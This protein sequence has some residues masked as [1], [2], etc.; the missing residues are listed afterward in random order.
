MTTPQLHSLTPLSPA[1][2]DVDA[3][4]RFYE[5]ALGFTTLFK[6]GQ[7]TQIAMI[8][9]GDISIM[10]C[11]NADKNL[12]D[13]TAFRI[14]TS[15]IESLYQE[16]VGKTPCPIHPNGKLEKKPWGSTEFAVLDPAGVC[17]TFYEFSAG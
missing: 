9:R 15:N 17:I 4:V 6:D 14:R 2:A 12:A 3:T 8:K 5:E 11:L 10:L 13:N 7:P 1:G 16:F